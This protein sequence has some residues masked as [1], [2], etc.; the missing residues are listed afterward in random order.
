MSKLPVIPGA[1]ASD[2]AAAVAGSQVSAPKA[3]D[4]SYC[5]YDSKRTGDWV[6]GKDKEPCTGEQIVVDLTSYKHGYHRWHQKKLTEA[7]AAPN[8]P[9]PE[10]P[11]PIHWE[12]AKGQP[13]VSES[14]EARSV[15]F[16]F[17]ED[18]LE[19]AESAQVYEFATST[20]GGV[21]TMSAWW[22]EVVQRAVAK[23]P[24][25]FPIIELRTSSYD[26]STYGQIFTPEM[27]VVGWCDQEGNSEGST[28]VL[29]KPA[30]DDEPPFETEEQAAP[31]PKTEGRRR[32]RR[33]A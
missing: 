13:Q 32:R 28:P 22:D 31:E 11:P 6:V 16:Q 1:N 2:L 25:M 19:D 24:F 26:H 15:Q 14:K 8:Q 27:A 18:V 21:S 23:N 20:Y 3:G 30:G 10:A 17:L 12:D 4:V 5:L 9:L 33:A 7:M 29:E